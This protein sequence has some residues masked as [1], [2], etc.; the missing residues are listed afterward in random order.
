ML[1]F[2]KHTLLHWAF[3]LFTSALVAGCF[4]LSLP[5]KP[6]GGADTYGAGGSGNKG[7]GGAG[8]TSGTSGKGVTGGTSGKAAAGSATGGAGNTS[9]TS[10]KAVA[11]SGGSRPF[12][13]TGGSIGDGGSGG[14]ACTCSDKNECCDGC[15]PINQGGSC[16]AKYCELYTCWKTPPPGVTGCYNDSA[17]IP[18]PGTAG[19]TECATTDFCGQDAQHP[20]NERTFTESTVDSDVIVTDSL[21]KLIWQKTPVTTKQTWQ[22]A[23]DY[24]NALTYAGQTG[25]RLPDINELAS[26][27]SNGKH[28]P[29]SDFPSMPSSDF[30]SSSSSVFN[31]VHAWYVG[32]SFGDVVVDFK[33]DAYAARCVR[34][35]PYFASSD[36]RFYVT[37]LTGQQTVLD[38]AT[39]LVWQQEYVND[40]L[41]KDALLYCEGLNYGGYSDWRVPNVNELR[42]LVNYTKSSPASDF[43]GMPSNFWSSSSGVNSAVLAWFVGFS[44][45]LVG[46]I[47]K[48]STSAARCVRAGP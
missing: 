40:K 1:R 45:G 23:I 41:W 21:T 8:N 4:D 39:G 6:D 35:G 14:T 48:K 22:Q 29:A 42:G 44:D 19:S 37:G 38:R 30:W 32:F 18:C 13:G 43:P 2:T 11:G 46:S 27:V 5:D 28:I 9:G 12:G 24:C 10:G 3:A 36:A 16:D 26:L 7:N 25:W 47:D 34:A 15:S 31:A 17:A 20:D 33:T